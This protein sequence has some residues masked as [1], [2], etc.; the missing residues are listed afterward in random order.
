MRAIAMLLFLSMAGTCFAED[1][2]ETLNTVE[3]TISAMSQTLRRG[4]GGEGAGG[5]MTIGIAGTGARL[6]GSL[7]RELDHDPEGSSGD[8][9]QL[10]TEPDRPGD[11]VLIPDSDPDNCAAGPDGTSPMEEERLP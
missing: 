6:E 2:L 11:L 9:V 7:E 1:P 3:D 8:D 4:P 5:D 10:M